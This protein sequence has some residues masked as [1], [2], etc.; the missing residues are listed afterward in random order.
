MTSLIKPSSWLFAVKRPNVIVAMC[1]LVIAAAAGFG[2]SR[3]VHLTNAWNGWA[4]P[5]LV[6]ASDPSTKIVEKDYLSYQNLHIANS[7]IMW[8]YPLS[9]RLLG[10]DPTVVQRLV[11]YCSCL[12]YALA[13]VF[14]VRSL[15]PAGPSA[16]T[17]VAVALAIL[18]TTVDGDLAR[19]GQGNFSLGQ[20]YGFAVA[21]QMV[22]VAFA[23]RGEIMKCGISLASLIWI[24][25]MIAAITALVAGVVLAVPRPL[26]KSWSKYLLAFSLVCLSAAI[27]VAVMKEGIAPK[28]RMPFEEWIDW[29][30]FSNCHWFPFEL[31]VFTRENSR[32]VAPLLAILLLAFAG[33]S[34]KSFPSD[35]PLKWFVAVVV[36]GLIVLIGLFNSIAPV[37]MILT[38]ASLHRATGL[39]LLLAL[40]FA[41]LALYNAVKDGWLSRVLAVVVMTTPF[42]GAYGFPLLPA[43]VL[44]LLKRPLNLSLSKSWRRDVWAFG[45][46]IAGLALADTLWLNMQLGTSFFSSSLLGP[47]KAW[48][49]GGVYGI[50]SFAT[51]S[52]PLSWPIARR[53]T[54]NILGATFVVLISLQIQDN[55]KRHPRVDNRKLAEDYLKVQQ[56]ARANTPSGALF[57][58]DPSH[59]YGWKD[60]SARPSWGNFRDWIHSSIVYHA[61][62]E[63]F[64]E[65]LRRARRLGVDPKVYVDRAKGAGELTNGKLYANLSADIK[66]AYYL[67]NSVTAR[68]LA[69]EEKIDFFVFQREFAPKLNDAPEFANA[70]FVVYRA[71]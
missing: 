44:F 71:R 41:C 48:F 18:T 12:L 49:L 14:F 23:I 29:V 2:Y 47:H 56:W 61:D 34:T 11:I 60:Y 58:T 16:V 32:L 38:M 39:M 22:V 45:L 42:L 9:N 28:S 36:C 40:P 31:G 21:L 1:A 53:A 35:R 27:Y 59:C 64:N 15:V 63:L 19:F 57:M 68:Q 52:M 33:I 20:Y 10:G 5:T 7:L 4:P 6:W 50:V 26:W 66:K 46:F 69:K 30:R 55:W 25:P 54:P 17:V 67:L 51:Q 62:T 8:V 24:H 43:L 13:V 65:G 70:S 37:S 3:D